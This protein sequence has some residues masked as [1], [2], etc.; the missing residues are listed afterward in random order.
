M[1]LPIPT[2]RSYLE[3]WKCRLVLSNED[4]FCS[5]THGGA[6]FESFSVMN[7]ESISYRQ[8]MNEYRP[9]KSLQNPDDRKGLLDCWCLEL[10]CH[11]WSCN[12][13]GGVAG[14]LRRL[15]MVSRAD[16][17]MSASVIKQEK[18]RDIFQLKFFQIKDRYFSRII[19]LTSFQISKCTLMP[20]MCTSSPSWL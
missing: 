8:E 9:N 2:S 5:L 1:L 3:E 15:G 13:D 10:R 17:M 14:R 6:Q 20:H 16:I 18:A 12:V 7:V 11:C 4:V 19:N